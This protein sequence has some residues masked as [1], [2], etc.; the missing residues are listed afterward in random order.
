MSPKSSSEPE[1]AAWF[2]PSKLA[3]WLREGR[4]RLQIGVAA[5][6]AGAE[7]CA[8]PRPAPRPC[9]RAFRG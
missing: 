7:G 4:G 8:A 9:A 3:G 5:A 1:P 2:Q 6:G